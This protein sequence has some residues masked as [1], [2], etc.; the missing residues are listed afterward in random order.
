MATFGKVAERKEYPLLEQGEYCLTLTELEESA[1]NWG[2]RM[3]WKFLISPISD[4]TAFYSRGGD[5]KAMSIWVFTDRDIILGSMGHQLVE[6]ITARAFGKDDEPPD[7]VDLVGGRVIAYLAH[8]TPKTGKSAG[9]KRE[10]VTDGSIKPFRVPASTSKYEPSHKNGT[11]G[12]VSA[13]PTDDEIDRATLVTDLQKR[14]ARLTKLDADQGQ[15]AQ[16]AVDKF[17]LSTVGT[18]ALESLIARTQ[19]A[20]ERAL[21]D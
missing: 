1:G 20:I 12:Q 14:V 8:E 16:E 5:D 6:A 11:A 15:K 10:K 4:Y 9:I 3:T 2:D 19:K 7:E 18:D 13:N 17:D 21:D